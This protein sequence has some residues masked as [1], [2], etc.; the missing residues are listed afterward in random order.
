MKK[1]SLPV[2]SLSILVLLSSCEKQAHDCNLVAA[3]IIRYDCDRVIFQ[4]LTAESIGDNDW[5]DVQTGLHYTNVVSYYNTCTIAAKTNGQLATLY[6]SLRKTNDLLV[7]SECI[8]CQALAD[9]PPRTK[10]DL[11]EIAVS[12]CEEQTQ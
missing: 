5:T 9:H 10:V 11:L 8:Q 12:P 6:V 4:L 1:L 3:K 2:V 7:D